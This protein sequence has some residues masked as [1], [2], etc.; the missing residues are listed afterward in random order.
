MKRL[1]NPKNI[2]LILTF[3]FAWGCGDDAENNAVEDNVAYIKDAYMKK[4]AELYVGNEDA[5]ILAIPVSMTHVDEEK[6]VKMNID[7]STEVLDAYN[8]KY[9]KNYVMYPAER[10]KFLSKE[11][12]IKKGAA[13]S[14]AQLEISPFT[15]DLKDSGDT[16][17]IP[18][19]I[20]KVDGAGIM[21]GS[22]SFIYI[23]R[24]IPIATTGSVKSGANYIRFA[25]PQ[26]EYFEFTALT[27][28]FLFNIETFSKTNNH[29]MF[30]N[31]VTSSAN[32]NEGS[33]FT[34]LENGSLGIDNTYFE[35]SIGDNVFVTGT[36]NGGKFEVGK[37]YHIACVYAS[38]KIYLYINGNLAA[39]KDVPRSSFKLHTEVATK[40]GG[41][42]FG[43]GG[44]GLTK[45]A[46]VR[47]WNVERTQEQIKE[48]MYKVNPKTDGLLGYWKINEGSGYELTDATGNSPEKAYPNTKEEPQWYTNQQL[49]V[50]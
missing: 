27:A 46:E 23:L 25:M 4:Y 36:P 32:K 12:V 20:A 16:Y 50:E 26:E 21:K 10:R 39:K 40:W 33:I 41:F 30:Y 6:E 49:N 1:I 17:A 47:L 44:I 43:G 37:W 22:E 45:V 11:V 7:F 28:E 18:V 24:E 13:A 8:K 42:N 35:F 31:N 19:T 29:V 34:R 5:T 3:V 38:K 48:N 9:N 2:I 15:Q 14:S